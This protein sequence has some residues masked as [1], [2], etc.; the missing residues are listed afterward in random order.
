MLKKNTLLACGWA[1]FI[2]AIPGA[3]NNGTGDQNTSMEIPASSIP[4]PA[5][6]QVNMVNAFPHDPSSYVQGLVIHDGQLFEGTG[7]KPG[8]NNYESRV[9]R[10][11]LADGKVLNTHKL[12]KDYFGE[13]ITVMN[14]KLYQITWT[15]KK[16]FIY[17]P[18]TLQK[19]GEFS[20]NTEGWGLTHDG[21]HLILSDGSSNLYFLNP[22]TFQTT[23]ILSVTDQYGPVNNLNEL[24]YIDGFIYANKWQTNYI[25]KINPD[26]GQVV[27]KADLSNLLDS[28][29]AQ[30]FKSVDYNNGDA[31]LNGIAYDAATG[32][33]YITG[34]LW[35]VLFEVKFN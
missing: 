17:D 24:E 25:L 31:V 29:K 18:A 4:A 20:I 19:T 15:E 11:N 14:N 33:I 32:K 16:G 28:N 3:C 12:G 1:C 8:V 27:G 5:V 30:Y 10:I 21:T 34:K 2:A 7:G 23:R 6:L 13:G 26:N 22:E 9:S 35:P